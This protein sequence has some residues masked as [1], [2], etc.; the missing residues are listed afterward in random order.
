M[1]IVKNNQYLSWL[2]SAANMKLSSDAPVLSI[3]YEGL[4]NFQPFME[5]NHD[6]I[7][8]KQA[9]SKN[10]DAIVSDAPNGIAAK[11]AVLRM[12]I[13]TISIHQLVVA[14]NA[15]KYYTVIRQTPNSNNMYYVNLI[16]E[17][18]TD[19]NAYVQMKKQTYP[20]VLLVSDK[21][22]YKK[23]TKWVP[24]FEDAFLRTSGSKG[25]LVYIN[26]EN[27]DVTDVRDD[28]LMA[29]AHYDTSGDMLE[30]LIHYF[31]HAGSIFCDDNKT[32]F[33]MISKAIAGTSVELTIK[34][35]SIRKDGWASFLALI[36]NHADDTKY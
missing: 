12:N 4:T 10:I 22:K 7:E 6:S 32:V 31:P 13:S 17:F 24:L 30:E 16:G 29:N 3:T 26:K 1:P 5:F 9:C 36:A 25:P 19:Y 15:V 2:K 23:I 27:V 20:E 8:S 35:Y 33:V 18:T 28:L 11:N 34:S 21:G 14:T